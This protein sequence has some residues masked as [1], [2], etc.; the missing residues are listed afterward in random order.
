MS[1]M[2]LDAGTLEDL[3]DILIQ[4]DLGLATSARIAKAVGDGRYDKQIEPAEVKAI[5]AREVETI[6]LPVAQP[7][8]I[9]LE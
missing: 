5:L 7:L 1:T 6:L 3:E 8:A 4:A 9:D 2:K